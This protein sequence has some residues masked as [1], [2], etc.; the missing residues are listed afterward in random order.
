M[1]RLGKPTLFCFFCTDVV[2]FDLSDWTA[3]S[4]LGMILFVLL[5]SVVGLWRPSSARKHNTV[6]QPLSFSPP[7]S[8]ALLTPVFLDWRSATVLPLGQTTWG[9]LLT[10]ETGD[11]GM[12]L[13]KRLQCTITTF[14]DI[15]FNF[16]FNWIFKLFNSSQR[17]YKIHNSPHKT[18]SQNLV[19]LINVFNSNQ[20]T[21]QN[22]LFYVL[23][24]RIIQD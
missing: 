9:K 22:I 7:P 3:L 4:G 14:G 2:C 18:F 24:N 10:L 19:A 15:T 16:K 23:Q 12:I 8:S 20:S 11:T 5:L 1:S 21:I 6:F 13:S 17:L